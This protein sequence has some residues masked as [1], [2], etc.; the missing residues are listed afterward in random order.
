MMCLEEVGVNAEG[1]VVR[2]IQYSPPSGL[3]GD[4]S[5]VRGCS[6]DLC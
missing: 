2:H 1:A 6:I 4:L 5:G 3:D